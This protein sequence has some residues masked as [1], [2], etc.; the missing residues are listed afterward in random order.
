M[1]EEE[2]RQWCKEVNMG[3][4]AS[5]STMAGTPLSEVKVMVECPACSPGRE[6]EDIQSGTIKVRCQQCEGEFFQADESGGNP[7]ERILWEKISS[8]PT[9]DGYCFACDKATKGELFCRCSSCKSTAALMEKCSVCWEN[10][11]VLNEMTALD[12]CGHRFCNTCWRDHCSTAIRQLNLVPHRSSGFYTVQCPDANCR[13]C[14]DDPHFIKQFVEPTLYDRM[15]SYAVEN[16]AQ[17]KLGAVTCPQQTCGS[18]MIPHSKNPKVTCID[19]QVPFCASCK[20][21]WHSGQTCEEFLRSKYP[22]SDEN[23]DGGVMG[24]NIKQCPNPQCPMM[25]EKQ[26]GTCNYMKCTYCQHVFCWVCLKPWPQDPTILGDRFVVPLH[27][28]NYQKPCQCPKWVDT[29]ESSGAA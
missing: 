15:K 22:A 5:S 8:A 23:P 3:N 14:P 18:V 25:I 11:D 24:V 19:C 26:S 10:C 6:D 28:I 7:L 16:F 21:D 12:V 4:N 29:S 2:R 1:R 17:L 9:V 20:V 13:E 27:I